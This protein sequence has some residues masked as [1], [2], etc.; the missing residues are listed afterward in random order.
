MGEGRKRRKRCLAK[1][2]SAVPKDDSGVR[3]VEEGE[4]PSAP[5]AT[6]TG[7]MTGCS[8]PKTLPLEG[9]ETEWKEIL[10]NGV[11]KDRSY[12]PNGRKPLNVYMGSYFIFLS[13]SRS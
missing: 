12:D 1:N 5:F 6:Q 13:T 10:P 8:C 4:K 11:G 3:G 7:Q 2:H 9:E